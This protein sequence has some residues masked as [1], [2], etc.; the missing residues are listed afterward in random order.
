VVERAGFENQFAGF[1]QRGFESPPL[2]FKQ[3][4]RMQGLL[5]YPS[6][7]WF[8][9]ACFKTHRTPDTARRQQAHRASSRI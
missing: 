6:K 9:A 2:R 3:P 4:L 7:R 8:N 5:L 1:L